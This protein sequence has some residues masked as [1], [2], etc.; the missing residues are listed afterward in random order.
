VISSSIGVRR[1]E[2]VQSCSGREV[3]AGKAELI[4]EATGPES[5]LHG[6]DVTQCHYDQLTAKYRIVAPDEL[7]ELL[8]AI[9]FPEHSR[10]VFALRAL[11]SGL[12]ALSFGLWHWK[13]TTLSGSREEKEALAGSQAARR[14][15]P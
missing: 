5:D 8:R 1:S 11:H 10:E 7:P 15:V 13:I 4:C 12:W 14:P 3:V 2:L 9:H 6:V